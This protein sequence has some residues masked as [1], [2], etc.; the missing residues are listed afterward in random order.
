MFTSETLIN[1]PPQNCLRHPK[2]MRTRYP[3]REVRQMALSQMERVRQGHAPCVQPVIVTLGPGLKFDPKRHDPR[4]EKF[5]LVGGHLRA[6]GAKYARLKTINAIVKNYATESEL[7]SEMRAENGVRSDISPLGW[8]RHYQDSLNA[9]PSLTLKRLARESGKSVHFVTEH[10]KLLQLGNTAQALIDAGELPRGSFE[11]L[12][13]LADPVVQVQAAKDFARAHTTLKG[14]EKRVGTLLNL[15]RVKPRKSAA[16][17]RPAVDGLPTKHRAGLVELR[18]AAKEACA[19]CDIGQT[20]PI[21]EPAWHVFISTA[22]MTCDN[23]GLQTVK[24]GC[25]GCP[26]AETMARLAR[27]IPATTNGPSP[28]LVR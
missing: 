8:A 17:K 13:Q 14:M 25:N 4:Q 15:Q 23:C 24:N 21:A 20:L 5:T 27:T 2:N 6:E 28:V 3:L 22:G 10:L 18:A 12:V 9:D 1:I 7:L 16:S 19:Q 11:Y 26:L